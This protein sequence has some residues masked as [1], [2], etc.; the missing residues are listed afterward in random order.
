MT[1][2][3]SFIFIFT[4]YI[5]KYVCSTSTSGQ[6]ARKVLYCI[7]TMFCGRISPETINEKLPLFF[8]LVVVVY[9]F[10]VIIVNCINS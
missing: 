2:G 9:L 4:F 6:V 1:M 8:V 7:P 3:K 5:E 10:A